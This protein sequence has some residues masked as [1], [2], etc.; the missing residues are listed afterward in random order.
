M[1]FMGMHLI[2]LLAFFTHVTAFDWI[3]CAALYVV[4]MFFVTGGYHR[5]FSH[6]AFKTSRF[7]QFILAGGAQSSFQKGVL[8]WA[9]NH[10]VH[11]KHSD[12]PEDPHSAN[13]YGFWYAHIGWIM[14]PEYK[15]TRYE[16]IKDMKHKELYWLNKYHFVP[17]VIL[18]IAVYFVGNK[19]NGTGFFD[20][21]AGV[22]TLLIGFFL[23]TII[24]FHG[25]FTINS[26]MH[27]IGKQRYKTGDQSRNSLV[28]ALVTLGEGWHNNHHYY[29]SAARQ[30]FYW[31]EIDI[32]Y[33]IIR[34][35]G[36]LGIVWDIRGVPVKVKESN[37]L[38]QPAGNKVPIPAPE[39]QSEN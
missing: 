21:G 5:Y 17:P 29:Q 37:K 4:R 38:N 28:L 7:F 1:D 20:W 32:T 30:G 36:A 13:L 8:W 35:L 3:L 18:A 34:T 27:K 9:A 6:R 19:V 2:P 11:H 31:W 24:L 23:S 25:T 22:S 33:Y 12:T 39:Y 10:R 16:L 14:G 15:P 26:L